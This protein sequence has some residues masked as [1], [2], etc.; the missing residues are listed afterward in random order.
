MV[1]GTDVNQSLGSSEWDTYFSASGSVENLGSGEFLVLGDPEGTINNTVSLE[2]L[3]EVGEVIDSVEI[4]DANAAS[5][6]DE[7]CYRGPDGEWL[8][9]LASPGYFLE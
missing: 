9:G 4:D 5:T 3:N 2:L 6:D 8:Q 1:D 7:A